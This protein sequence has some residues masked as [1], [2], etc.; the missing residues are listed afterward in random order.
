MKD[1]VTPVPPE[2]VRGMIKKCLETAALLNY[3]RLSSEAKIEGDFLNIVSP[4]LFKIYSL[5]VAEDLRGETMVPPSKKLDDLIHLAELCV[6]L[7][8]QNEEHYAEVKSLLLSPL[9]V[10][11]ELKINANLEILT[12]VKTIVTIII[13]RPQLA[14]IDIYTTDPY[15]STLKLNLRL[16]LCN[17][18]CQNRCL[19]YWFMVVF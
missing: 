4:A 15:C 18:L 6:D 5:D 19:V 17:L 9:R 12:K 10:S 3:T 14:L 7:L 13:N 16:Q 2:E 8:Q 1:I 11:C